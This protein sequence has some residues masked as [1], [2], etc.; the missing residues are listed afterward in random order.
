MKARRRS[1]LTLISPTPRWDLCYPPRSADV[2]AE[3]WRSLSI[4]IVS[5]VPFSEHPPDE[6]LAAPLQASLGLWWILNPFISF[7]H[8]L[9]L[10]REGQVCGGEKRLLQIRMFNWDLLPNSCLRVWYR[11]CSGQRLPQLSPPGCVVGKGPWSTSARPGKLTALS[12][13][14]VEAS[15]LWKKY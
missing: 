2:D 3:T 9:K 5:C 4:I 8:P 1:G 11:L 14:P 12:C 7:Q 6:P 13:T 15:T 10:G